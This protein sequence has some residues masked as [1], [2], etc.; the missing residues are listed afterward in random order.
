[1]ANIDTLIIFRIDGEDAQVLCRTEFTE[2]LE[3]P[4]LINTKSHSAFVRFSNG[5]EVV[6]PFLVQLDPPVE[7]DYSVKQQ[8]LARRANYSNPKPEALQRALDSMSATR[9]FVLG[10]G[11]PPK[12]YAG[13]INHVSIQELTQRAIDDTDANSPEEMNLLDL[14]SNNLNPESYD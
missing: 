1:M 9:E 13:S 5:K 6:G 2:E 11:N 14:L 4:S 12:S 8:I 7:G 3:A 10:R